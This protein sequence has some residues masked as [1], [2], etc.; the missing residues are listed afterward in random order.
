MTL[1]LVIA[2]T[3][4][5]CLLLAVPVAFSLIITGTV[6]MLWMGDIPLM[7]VPHQVIAGVDSLLLLAIPFFLLAGDLMNSGGITQRLLDFT[8]ALVGRFRGGLALSNVASA[9]IM[10]GI[11][12]SAVADT[13]ALGRVLIPAMAKD[14]YHRGFAAALTGVANIV[15]P[16]IPPSITFVLIGVL[17]NL[18]ITKLFM[19]GILPGILYS[20]AIAITAYIICRRRGYPARAPASATQIWATFKRSFWALMMPVF[21]LAG[22]RTG[23]FNVT[24]CSAMAVLY[25]I[26]VGGFVYRELKPSDVLG[27]LMRTGRATAVLMIVLGGAQVVAW[28]LAYQDIPQAVADWMLSAVKYPWLLLLV[29]NLLLLA[30]GTFM[31]NGPALVILAPVLYPIAAKFGIDPYHFSMIVG[32]NLVLGLITPPVAIS[33]SIGAVIANAP[34]R[35]VTREAMPFFAVAVGVLMLITFVPQISLVIPQLMGLK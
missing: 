21:I 23:V 6:G 14:G 34:Q 9:T 15:G 13:S 28:L 2:I 22:I 8:N 32:L 7:A 12:G 33:L 30:V 18:S 19:A 20:V 24:E 35:E 17:P 10:S 5:G 27:A 26:V 4:I 31:E 16:I 29:V 11:S 1:A 3:L 25:A